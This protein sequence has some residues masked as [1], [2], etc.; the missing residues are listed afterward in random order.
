LSDEQKF[1]C[2]LDLLGFK[3]RIDDEGFRKSY[4]RINSELIKPGVNEGKIYLISD[5]VV[6]ISEDFRT[7]ADNAFSI[8]GFALSYGILMRGAITEGPLAN[9]PEVHESNNAV[10]IP[11]LGSTYK[12]AYELEGS[13]N[14][15]GICLDDGLFER[16]SEDDQ[17][18]I[19][20]YRELFPKKNSK[21]VSKFLISDMNNFN[22]PQTILSDIAG[23]I[24]NLQNHEI[25]KFIDTFCLYYKVM[26]EKHND[27]TNKRTYHQWW[28]NILEKLNKRS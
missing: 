4:E 27:E 23:Q 12:N 11:Y 15:A 1:L 5:S 3:N 20:E 18:L 19:F 13:I 8:Y 26:T 17:E 22:V 2:Y 16:L 9:L 14:C 7:V 25:S 6:I 10:L 21:S 28:L 24:E